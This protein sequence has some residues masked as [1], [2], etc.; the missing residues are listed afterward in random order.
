VPN[1]LEDLE[2]HLLAER[3][4]LSRLHDVG[5]A[6]QQIEGMVGKIN[7]ALE[8]ISEGTYGICESCGGP[9]RSERL[10]AL[11]YATRCIKCQR[12]DEAQP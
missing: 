11:P 1:N 6:H 8:K 12:K 2:Q 4:Q 9:I 5:A 7:E 10:E 3:E